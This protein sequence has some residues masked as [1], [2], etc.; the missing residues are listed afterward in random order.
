MSNTPTNG[1]IY[2]HGQ[3]LGRFSQ[4]EPGP[5]HETPDWYSDTDGTHWGVFHHRTVHMIPVDEVAHL[6]PAES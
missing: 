4:T 5:G 3:P 2:V 1:D 6:T